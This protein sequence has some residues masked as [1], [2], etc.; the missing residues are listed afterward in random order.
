MMLLALIV[1]AAPIAIWLLLALLGAAMGQAMGVVSSLLY[2]VG[3][4]ALFAAGFY[5]ARLVPDLSE[6]QSLAVG[7]AVP[8]AYAAGRLIW[9]KLGLPTPYSDYDRWRRQEH[10]DYWN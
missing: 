9:V 5:T 2:L 6:Q 3:A 10:R 8:I 1:I 7:I 4:G